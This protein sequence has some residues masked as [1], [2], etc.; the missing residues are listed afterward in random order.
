MIAKGL[1]PFSGAEVFAI[2]ES[3]VSQAPMHNSQPQM[4]HART[5]DRGPKLSRWCAKRVRASGWS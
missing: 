3:R 4:P 5:A 1:T 2:M